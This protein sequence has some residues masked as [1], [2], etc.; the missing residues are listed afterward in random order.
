M[1]AGWE[2]D[3]IVSIANEIFGRYG[4][5]GRKTIEEGLN[6]SA[7]DWG[8]ELSRK[9]KEKTSPMAFVRH[10][11]KGSDKSVNIVEQGNDHVVIS[12]K[13][14]KSHDL[15]RELGKLEL[16]CRFKCQQDYS[17]I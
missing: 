2:P 4:E 7:H 8:K 1:S 6:K 10:F 13:K 11:L 16:G 15:F 12:T 5:K 9:D 3:D 17:I 14:C